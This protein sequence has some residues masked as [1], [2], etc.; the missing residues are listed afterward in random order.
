MNS[1]TKL[2]CNLG[3]GIA[4][5]VA[6]GMIVKIPLIGHISTDFGYIVFGAY[7]YIFGLPAVVIGVIGCLIESLLVSG[8]IPIGWILGQLEIGLVCGYL[9]KKGKIISNRFVKAIIYFLVI[10]VSVTLGI[11]IIKTIVE[12]FLYDIPF[13]VKIVKNMIA[14][15]CDILT[16][17]I[18]VWLACLLE[19]RKVLK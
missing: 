15:I 10:C 6:L 8:W 4:L 18:G 17:S 3:I 9:F 5:Y 19:K 7:L 12:C 13:N 11:G 2:L 14:T 16:M 1:K